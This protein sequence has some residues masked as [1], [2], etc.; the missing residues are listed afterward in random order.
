[1]N[2]ARLPVHSAWSTQI[3]GFAL[4]PA[5][6][7]WQPAK[8][9][10]SLGQNEAKVKTFIAGAMLIPLALSAATAYV[11][12]RLGSKDEGFPSFLGYGVGVLGALGALTSLLV[13]LGVI[14]TP[15]P[16]RQTVSEGP[17][18]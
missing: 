16:T 10:V 13:T 18:A 2:I 1:M 11:G 8:L 9:P 17:I 14:A 15:F 3:R 5:P 7:A 6:V 12:F 4:P